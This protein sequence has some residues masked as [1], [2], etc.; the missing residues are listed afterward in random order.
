VISAVFTV[1]AFAGPENVTKMVA[2]VG[3][4]VCPDAGDEEATENTPDEV[5]VTGVV[6]LPE[7][8]PVISTTRKAAI[9]ATRKVNEVREKYREFDLFS[10]TL[11][12]PATLRW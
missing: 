1:D 7:E 8:Q 9:S 2:L 12:P 3:T 11:I 6:L 10:M 4:C 5:V